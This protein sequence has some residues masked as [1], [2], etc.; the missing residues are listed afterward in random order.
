[1]RLLLLFFSLLLNFSLEAAEWY[2]KPSGS[3]SQSGADIDNAIEGAGG[4][5]WKDYLKTYADKSRSINQ[6]QVG[7]FLEG[8]LTAPM[9]EQGAGVPQRAAMYAQAMRDAPG[10]IKRS[11]GNAR[12][13]DLGQILDPSQV[14]VAEGVA[15]DLGRS[16]ENARLGSIGAEKA[17]ALLGA[18]EPPLP[19]AGMFSP[20]YSVLRAISNRLHGKV[21]GK[22]LDALAKAMQDPQEMAR[23]MQMATPAQRQAMRPYLPIIGATSATNQGR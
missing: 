12:Y 19:A 6:M 7:Q 5:G 10:T 14:A 23:I 8:K 17:R 1:M 18:I 9:A 22:S 16:A 11:T 2:V 21:E 15:K 3:G 20:H 4:T 13:D